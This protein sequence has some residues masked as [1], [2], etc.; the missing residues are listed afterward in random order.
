LIK[1][2]CRMAFFKMCLADNLQDAADCGGLQVCFVLFYFNYTTLENLVDC[3][4]FEYN[5]MSNDQIQTCQNY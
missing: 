5:R 2:A 1:C 3:G 4:Y